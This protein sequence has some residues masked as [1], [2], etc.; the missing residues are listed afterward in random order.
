M[1]TLEDLINDTELPPGAQGEDLHGY[2]RRIFRAGVLLG[3]Q[4]GIRE[5]GQQAPIVIVAPVPQG[6]PA[7]D[8]DPPHQDAPTEQ[9]PKPEPIRSDGQ[10]RRMFALFTQKGFPTKGDGA[11]DTIL[12]FINGTLGL[13]LPDGTIPDGK[14][15]IVSTS[16]LT[17]VQCSAVMKALEDLP[18]APHGEEPPA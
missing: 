6:A 3:A 11:R 14:T 4:W 16:H 8:D 17:V 13:V 2:F 15:P 12:G 9:P 1:Q 10:S 7:R 18:D 5:A